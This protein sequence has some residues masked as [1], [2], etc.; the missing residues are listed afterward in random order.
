M[1]TAKLNYLIMSPRKV[2]MFTKVLKGLPVNQA[3]KKL[4][5]YNKRASDIL[6]KLLK[7]AINNAKN[8][9]YNENNLYIKN[10][11]VNEGPKHLKRYYPKARGGVGKIIKKMSHIEIILDTQIGSESDSDKKELNMKKV[12]TNK[13]S[14]NKKVDND[15]ETDADI[16]KDDQKDIKK[17]SSASIST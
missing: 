10:I 11:I 16:I 5:F 13:L 7:S 8:K 14:N 2:R 12:N 4:L 3:E 9:G 15:L 17:N 1:I 6:L